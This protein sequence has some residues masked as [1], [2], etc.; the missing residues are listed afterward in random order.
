MP[1]M[2]VPFVWLATSPPTAHAAPA[3]V[4]NHEIRVSIDASRRA[5][6]HTLWQVRIDDP[7]GCT[8]GLSAPPGLA[9]TSHD[10]AEVVGDLLV[11]PPGTQAG[12]VFTL[13][14]RTSEGR[15]AHSGLL[16]GSADLP[17]Q[18]TLLEVRAPRTTPMTVWADPSGVTGSTVDRW[19]TVTVTWS[20]LPAGEPAQAAFSTFGD[21]NAAADGVQSRIFANLGGKAAMGRA[22]AEN[23]QG[24]G[25]AG[26]V[27]RVI[28]HVD[29]D[30][31]NLG[32]WR[33]ARSAGEVRHTARGTAAERGMVMLALLR[34]A[35]FDARPA[36]FRPASLPGAIPVT[37]PAPDAFTHPALVVYRADGPVYIDPAAPRPTVPELPASMVGATLWVPGKIPFHLG[38]NSVADGHVHLSTHVVLD[39]SGAARWS[40]QLHTSGAATEFL[41]DR[42]APL[43]DAARAE[44]FTQ[45][46]RA[47]RPD[48]GGVSTVTHHLGDASKPLSV[49]LSGTDPQALTPADFGLRGTVLPVLAPALTAWLS[50]RLRIEETMTVTAPP[51]T[52]VLGASTPQPTLTT[53]ALVTRTVDRAGGVTTLTVSATR[54]ER[55]ATATQ[56]AAAREFLAREAGLGLDLLVLHDAEPDTVKALRSSDSVPVRDRQVLEALL[57]LAADNRGK[58][59]RLLKRAIRESRF[60]DV[61]DTVVRW[62]D[63]Q[64][65]RPWD[66]LF[67]IAKD[68]PVPRMRIVRGLLD[69]G[70]VGR[71]W[72][73]ALPLRGSPDP[74]VRLSALTLVARLQGPRP[75]PQ[76]DPESAS[77]WLDP[78]VL[79]EEGRISASEILEDTPLPDALALG[80]ARSSLQV[81]DLEGARALLTGT[82]GPWAEALSAQLDALVGLGVDQVRDRLQA[83]TSAAP[84]DPE[85]NATAADA[86]AA[87]GDVQAAAARALLAARLADRDAHLW[88]RAADHALAAGSLPTA[89]LSS[90]R[91]SDLDPS[92]L[93]RA[94]RWATLAVALQDAPSA[95]AAHQRLGEAAPSSWPDLGA[96]MALVPE[97]PLALLQSADREVLGDPALLAMRAQMRIHAG[98]LEDAARD[99]VVL[100]TTH[101]KGEGW[102]LAFAATAGRQISTPLIRSLDASARTDPA[103]QMTRLEY[104]LISG[105]GEL[106]ADA[107]RLDSPRASALIEGVRDPEA[108]A[109]QLEGWPAQVPPPTAR[110]P[111]GWRRNEALSAHPGVAAYSDPPAAM[112]VMWVGRATGVVPPPLGLLFTANPQPIE[113]LP[114]G[115]VLRLDGGTLPVYAA[116][117]IHD[118]AEVF[119]LGFTVPAA[120]RALDA[121]LAA[122]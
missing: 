40:T 16:V 21:W 39:A 13:E 74:E 116:T 62:A 98:L 100:G 122:H 69:A 118:G 36:T 91:A 104:R 106:L 107:E 97:A 101:G 61:T 28:R 27:E 49:R 93:T 14:H 26:I 86:L 77:L 17:A 52:F 65:P 103:A 12:A 83:A 88:D 56:Q 2:L 18:H 41:R 43:D 44:A 35:G 99:A 50:P 71:A 45:L 48:S 33:A 9:G 11:I 115:V 79:L 89:L 94:R 113:T 20:D 119:G 84:S 10:G 5:R 25:I 117:T 95:E 78:D 85:V 22:L 24:L 7:A 67:A 59:R 37:V 55:R 66:A 108:A 54:P 23:L 29:V 42:L 57:L 70:A 60:G 109:A 92:S 63:P 111:R 64:D 32:S 121:A 105:E 76:L 4:L 46:V 96:R 1:R 58:G 68:Q 3:T 38:R 6:R 31:G 82:E 73:E 34:L 120:K 15:G 51:G 19:R 75:D 90:R 72:R 8:N 80:L 87:V 30:P 110:A 81:G 102:A 114:S 53:E 47:S 112:A